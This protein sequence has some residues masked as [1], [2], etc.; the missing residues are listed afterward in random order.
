MKDHCAALANSPP[1]RPS[2]PAYAHRLKPT[3]LNLESSCRLIPKHLP[4]CWLS[5]TCAS[6][7]SHPMKDNQHLEPHPK[8]KT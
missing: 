6:R 4:V 7:E 8:I 1:A 2:I 3:F 5:K